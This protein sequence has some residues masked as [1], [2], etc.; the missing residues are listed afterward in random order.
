MT[1]ELLPLFITPVTL[2]LLVVPFIAVVVC[3]DAIRWTY[4][5]LFTRDRWLR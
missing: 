1:P 3:C 5:V 2:T 4:S